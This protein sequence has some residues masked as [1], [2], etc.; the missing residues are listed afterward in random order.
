MLLLFAFYFVGFC[1][2]IFRHSYGGIKLNKLYYPFSVIMT[3]VSN[4]VI[5]T[6]QPMVH[7]QSPSLSIHITHCT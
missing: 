7:S 1:K 2:D 5:Y 6:I 4:V 3:S